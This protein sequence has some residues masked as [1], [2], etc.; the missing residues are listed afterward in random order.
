MPCTTRSTTRRNQVANQDT[1]ARKKYTSTLPVASTFAPIPKLSFDASSGSDNSF[2][3]FP[4]TPPNRY[5]SLDSLS[6]NE[7]ELARRGLTALQANK[8][9]S[10]ERLKYWDSQGYAADED[11]SS[12]I[13]EVETLPRGIKGL[14]PQGTFL[15]SDEWHPRPHAEDPATTNQLPMIN[16]AADD[17]AMDHAQEEPTDIEVVDQAF[18]LPE[19][20]AGLRR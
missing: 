9:A 6:E 2:A 17:I 5:P 4:N 20:V 7:A 12:D 19:F 13:E 8:K 10:E 11:M 1:N 14:G 16:E 18:G 15:V 3:S